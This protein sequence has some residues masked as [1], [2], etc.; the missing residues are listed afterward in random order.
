M[1]CAVN[2]GSILDRSL[3]PNLSMKEGCLFCL[4]CSD[5]PNHAASC[6][7]LGTVGK[8]AMGRGVLT[9]FHGVLTMGISR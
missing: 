6:H 7:T 5:L 2:N 9:W 1:V 4:S 8:P 3:P